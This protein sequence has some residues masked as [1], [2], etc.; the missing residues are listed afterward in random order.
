MIFN[1][2]GRLVRKLE[3]GRKDPGV[4]ASQFNAH[5]WMEKNEL[6]EKGISGLYFYNI[7]AGDFSATKKMIVKK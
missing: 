3:L 7:K 6:G 5:I 1:A 4:Y 2:D